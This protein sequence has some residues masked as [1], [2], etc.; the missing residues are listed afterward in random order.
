MTRLNARCG[1][2]SS[3]FPRSHAETSTENALECPVCGSGL[4]HG[5]PVDPEQIG[6]VNARCTACGAEFRRTEATTNT[7]GVLECP[8]CGTASSMEPI[9]E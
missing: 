7:K 1:T 9:G 6:T 3:A 5:N 8:V 4:V 2:C